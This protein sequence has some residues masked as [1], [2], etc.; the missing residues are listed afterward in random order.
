[1]LVPRRTVSAGMAT[2]ELSVTSLILSA[3]RLNLYTCVR[4]VTRVERL[5]MKLQ[6]EK[7]AEVGMLPRRIDT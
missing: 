4:L 1:M 2:A 7:L 5:F 3:V 6:C